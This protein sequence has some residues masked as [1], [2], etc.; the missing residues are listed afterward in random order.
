VLNS[1]RRERAAYLRLVERPHIRGAGAAVTTVRVEDVFVQAIVGT[2][3]PVLSVPW[4]AEPPPCSGRW[5]PDAEHPT[6]VFLGRFDVYQKG[7]D[8]LAAI[9]SLCPEITF[10]LY[11]LPRSGGRREIERLL[12]LAPSNVRFH[13][14]VHGPA[15]QAVL[16]RATVYLQPSRFEGFSLAVVDALLAGTPVVASEHLGLTQEIRE[17]GAGGALPTDVGAAA[18]FLRD[19]IA[20][21]QRLQAW[22]AAGRAFAEPRFDAT[23]SAESYLSVYETVLR[24]VARRA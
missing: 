5:E 18:R 15:K 8:R 19:V 3:C 11:G 6:A 16:Q 23:R 4:P 14:P 9:A 12:A 2:A 17:S 13:A 1:R 20:D 7:L 10:S 21:R 22:S 24:G